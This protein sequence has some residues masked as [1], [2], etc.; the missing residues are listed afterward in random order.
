MFPGNK[1]LYNFPALEARG[2]D[3]HS[4]L[5]A[6]GVPPVSLTPGRSARCQTP[7][8]EIRFA[9]TSAGALLLPAGQQSPTSPHRLQ[10]VPRSIPRPPKAGARDPCVR[11]INAAGSSA[12]PSAP[13]PGRGRRGGVAA[14]QRRRGG[15]G[16]SHARR[17]RRHLQPGSAR[18]R[19]LP[20]ELVPG[21][22]AGNAP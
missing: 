18:L 8:A 3:P 7:E 13:L 6:S 9:E 15:P 21:R 14:P 12:P 11:P 4:S 19:A 1:L 16:P 10:A 22:W 20:S 2:G 5:E 17:R